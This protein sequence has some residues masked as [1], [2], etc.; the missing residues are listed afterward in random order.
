MS[1]HNHRFLA[2]TVGGPAAAILAKCGPSARRAKHE[3]RDRYVIDCLV[4]AGE[5]ATL[6]DQLEY[7]VFSLSGYR[8]SKTTRLG[9]PNR[10]D[11]IA[12]HLE[13]HVIRS[14]SM[15]DRALILT[16]IVFKLGLA[17]R[18]CSAATVAGNEHVRASSAVSKALE[19]LERTVKPLREHRNVIVHRRAYSDG[20][21]A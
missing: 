7:A 21:T 8:R 13:N 2:T 15:Y 9:Y 11:Y 18:V 20:E 14:V 12:Y 16:N 17:A 4:A 6:V 19:Q 10:A 1:L 5:I 3:P